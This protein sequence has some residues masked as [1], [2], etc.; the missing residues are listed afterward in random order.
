MR[1]CPRK[2]RALGVVPPRRL[3]AA[4]AGALAVACLAQIPAASA[5][6]AVAGS[7]QASAVGTKPAASAT[8]EQC[9][10]ALDEIE[11]SATFV[12]EMSAI[13]GSTRMEM[14][15]DLLERLPAQ[16][17]FHIVSAPGLGIW[18]GSAPG[19]KTF[20][21]LKQVT[22]LTAPASYRGTVRFRWLSAKGRLMRSLELRTASCAQPAAPAAPTS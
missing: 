6:A 5:G 22:N 20:K 12:G 18:R 11:R 7:R 16:T 21:Y 13:A 14:R 2:P 4:L 3:P 17:S 19:V 10:A 15:I 9:V 1:Y 8:L